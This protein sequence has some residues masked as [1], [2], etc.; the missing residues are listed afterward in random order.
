MHAIKKSPA[1][2]HRRLTNQFDNAPPPGSVRQSP[3]SKRLTDWQRLSYKMQN[4]WSESPHYLVS[5]EAPQTPRWLRRR[6]FPSLG[7]PPG[8]FK[9]NL[10]KVFR[11]HWG[12]HRL[13]FRSRAWGSLVLPCGW[14]FNHGQGCGSESRPLWWDSIALVLKGLE[15]L[16]GDA[17]EQFKSRYV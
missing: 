9:C 4:L 17:P 14:E 13:T 3:Q 5:Q 10:F 6:L 15:T 7:D 8:Q 12:L 16:P 1:S 2:E 11:S